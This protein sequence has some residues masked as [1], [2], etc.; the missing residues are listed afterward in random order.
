[1]LVH[2]NCCI[3]HAVFKEE[4]ATNIRSPDHAGISTHLSLLLFFANFLIPR[5]NFGGAVNVVS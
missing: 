3:L 2:I 4:S 1:M 5:S